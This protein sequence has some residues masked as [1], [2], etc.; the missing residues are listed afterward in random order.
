[1]LKSHP[2]ALLRPVMNLPTV[3]D[4]AAVASSYSQ[5]TSRLMYFFRAFSPS[6]LSKICC[7]TLSG[8][9]SCLR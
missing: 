2:I 7:L 6:S 1:M 4:L 9:S 3:S 8:M 5:S